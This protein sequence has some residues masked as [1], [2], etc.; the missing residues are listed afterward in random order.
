MPVVVLGLSGTPNAGD[1]LL[2]VESERKAREVALYRQGKFRDVKLARQSHR[3]SRTCSRRPRTRR[4]RRRAASLLKTDVQGSAEALRDA[5]AKLST[6]EVQVKVIASGVGGITESDV[7]LAAAS[8]ARIIGFNV[9]ADAAAREADQ[10]DG[11]RRALLQHHLR[12]HR[13]R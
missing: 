5:L 1:E 2:V 6:D 3:S 11:R 9:R 12:S 10:G 13:R 4:R 8:R 7:T